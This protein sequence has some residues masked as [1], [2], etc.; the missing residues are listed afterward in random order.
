MLLAVPPQREASIHGVAELFRL[1]PDAQVNLPVILRRI[2]EESDRMQDLVEDLLPPARLDQTRP[3]AREPVDLAVLAADACSDAVALDHGRPVTLAA[4]DPV[5]VRGDRDHM[6]HA[7]GNLVANAV[8]HTPAG[9]PIE[10][11]AHTAD[12]GAPRPHRRL[13]RCRPS[14]SPLPEGMSC[15]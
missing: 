10:V 3:V 11:A 4:S 8:Q 14:P 13:S 6:L 5:V 9:T 2:E 12:G 7:I 15:V 1:G